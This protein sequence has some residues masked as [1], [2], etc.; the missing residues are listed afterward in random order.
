M[1]EIALAGQL[2]VGLA[3][4]GCAAFDCVSYRLHLLQGEFRSASGRIRALRLLQASFHLVEL[5][6][7]SLQLPSL[8]AN[9]S[10]MPH[11][12]G[13]HDVC[14]SGRR[15]ALWWRLEEPDCVPDM[16]ERYKGRSRARLFILDLGKAH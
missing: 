7:A 8:P 4:A 6:A 5:V 16:K 14:Q 1:A 2:G 3:E 12:R 11:L 15:L 9:H 10:D 13:D